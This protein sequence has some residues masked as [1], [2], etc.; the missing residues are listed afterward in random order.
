MLSVKEEQVSDD[1][2]EYAAGE[3]KQILEEL[4]SMKTEMQENFEAINSALVQLLKGDNKLQ[5]F[6]EGLG[7]A[8]IQ[9]TV[10]RLQEYLKD[11]QER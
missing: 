7:E 2:E 6:V 8:R 10:K 4:E 1:G 9:D 3:K 11:K 5:R